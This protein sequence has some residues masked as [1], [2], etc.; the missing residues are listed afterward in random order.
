M[1]WGELGRRLAMGDYDNAVSFFGEGVENFRDVPRS[2]H[3]DIFQLCVRQMTLSTAV[4]R[5]TFQLIPELVADV[6]DEPLFKSILA[7]SMCVCTPL[8]PSIVGRAPVPPATV[9]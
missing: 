1:P 3:H 5:E 9:S 7:I 4:G 2:L 6:D 8:I